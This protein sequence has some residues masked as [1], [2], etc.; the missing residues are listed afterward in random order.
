MS[1]LEAGIRRDLVEIA[2]PL[3]RLIAL[4]EGKIS[5]GHKVKDHLYT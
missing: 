1:D 4:D 2:S 5:I 3:D